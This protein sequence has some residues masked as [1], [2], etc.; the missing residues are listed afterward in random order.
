M[1]S[2]PT[3]RNSTTLGVGLKRDFQRRIPGQTRPSVWLEWRHEEPFRAEIAPVDCEGPGQRAWGLA[4]LLFANKISDRP[5]LRRSCVD[6]SRWPRG[7]IMPIATVKPLSIVKM[8]AFGAVIG[9][10]YGFVKIYLDAGGTGTDG[11][12]SI[13]GGAVG[14]AVVGAVVSFI[15][16]WWV[17]R[18]K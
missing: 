10:V 16:N 2:P 18:A 7:G 6:V 4:S 14:G 9:A 3:R 12:G 1:V 11:L 13:V 5:A 8:A 17:T 15:R